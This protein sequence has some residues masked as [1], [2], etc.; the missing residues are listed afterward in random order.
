VSDLD[1]ASLRSAAEAAA[2]AGGEVILASFEAPPNVREKAQGD[3]VT[4]ADM[5]SER[6]VRRVLAELAPGIPVHGEEE[7]G[8][9]DAALHWLVDPL[10]GTANFVHGHPAVGCS[11][12]LVADGRPVVGVVHAPMLH[13]TFSAALGAGA[14][15]NDAP[16]AVS[17]RPFASGIIATGFP[18]RRKDLSETYLAALGRVHAAAEDLRRCGAASLDLCW[19]AAGVFDGYFELGLGPW[20]VA[21]GGLIVREAGGIVT[22]WFGDEDAWLG[23]GDIVAAPV[24]VHGALRAAVGEA[25]SAR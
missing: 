24:G 16:L 19:T 5:E 20:D 2:R 4:D 18:F 6:T 10:D 15:R 25:R 12:G 3:W 22:D 14:T 23:S 13:Q 9:R 1:L 21:A 7:G 17:D 11:V 8:D